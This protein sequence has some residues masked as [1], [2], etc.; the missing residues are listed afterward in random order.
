MFSDQNVAGLVALIGGVIT[1]VYT[2][3][4]NRKKDK[5]FITSDAAATLT[6]LISAQ[7]T[8]LLRLKREHEECMADQK[9]KDKE[10]LDLK[11]EIWQLNWR[12][13]RAGLP[14]APDPPRG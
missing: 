7:N 13:N 2:W 12:L 9:K 11:G 4:Q 3:F 14:Q 8:E 1:Y 5:K 6:S 10:I